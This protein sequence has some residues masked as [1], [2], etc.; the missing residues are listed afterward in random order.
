MKSYVSKW[1]WI[2]WHESEVS[3]NCFPCIKTKESALNP[4]LFHQSSSMFYSHSLSIINGCLPQMKSSVLFVSLLGASS[5]TCECNKFI[6]FRIQIR[7]K[8][9]ESLCLF[10]TSVVEFPCGFLRYCRFR[11]T[12]ELPSFRQGIYPSNVYKDFLNH[13]NQLFYH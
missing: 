5:F 4:Y 9:N 6:N 11:I 7:Q 10:C 8:S 13:S 2:L 3:L 12:I 1:F